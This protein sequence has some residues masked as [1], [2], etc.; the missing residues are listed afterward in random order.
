MV[1]KNRPS[2]KTHHSGREPVDSVVSGCCL[3][4]LVQSPRDKSCI[5]VADYRRDFQNDQRV[6]RDS[7]AG[8][9]P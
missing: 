9:S 4:E 6:S 1:H 8:W 5:A 7:W 2:S 3:G